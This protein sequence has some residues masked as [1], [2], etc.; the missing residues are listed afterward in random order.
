MPANRVEDGTT[1]APDGEA[2]EGRAALEVVVVDGL[3]EA[4]DAV[5]DRF[6]AI[7]RARPRLVRH[8]AD[9]ERHEGHVF[10][11]ISSRVSATAASR[12]TERGASSRTKNQ[13]A[14]AFLAF[15]SGGFRPPC[16]SH[17]CDVAVQL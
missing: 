15:A 2:G 8:P 11:I 17:P 14:G 6:F 10:E 4:F 16:A 3:D 9:D 7:E 5:G 1:D 12:N 13:D